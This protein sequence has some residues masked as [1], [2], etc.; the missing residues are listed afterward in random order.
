MKRL[1]LAVALALS[2]ATT[3]AFANPAAVAKWSGA[4][5]LAG[6]AFCALDRGAGRLAAAYFGVKYDGG[7]WCGK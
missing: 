6:E 1:I 5:V 4:T 7:A 2:F 3:P